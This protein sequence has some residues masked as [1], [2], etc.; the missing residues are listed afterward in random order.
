MKSE[1]VKQNKT[2]PL[3]NFRPHPQGIRAHLE[4]KGC[5]SKCNKAIYRELLDFTD[6]NETER[7]HDDLYPYSGITFH[8]SRQR[9][10][11]ESGYSPRQVRYALKELCNAK[12]IK[13]LDKHPETG[14]YRY[15][16]TTYHDAIEY[17]KANPDHPRCQ[18]S[19]LAISPEQI[20]ALTKNAMNLLDRVE[21]LK[22][23]KTDQDEGVQ[24][25]QGGGAV[26]APKEE[27]KEEK[28]VGS[29]PHPPRG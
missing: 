18:V 1:T 23:L 5:F 20:D 13:K 14:C 3:L 17:L 10:A 7:I 16:L 9:I 27:Y 4:E 12:V 25:L 21:T 29:S 15:E 11:D 26:T 22:P 6:L 8:I 24:A 19:T 2:I 28:K